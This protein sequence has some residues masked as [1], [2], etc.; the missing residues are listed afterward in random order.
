MATSRAAATGTTASRD[1]MGLDGKD[2]ELVLGRRTYEIFE[3]YWPYQAGAHTTCRSS[4]ATTSFG[5]C[6]PHR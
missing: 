2:R 3:A 6:A 5:R 1:M 4:A